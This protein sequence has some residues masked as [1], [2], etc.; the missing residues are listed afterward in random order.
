MSSSAKRNSTKRERCNNSNGNGNGNE[1]NPNFPQ[2]L[3]KRS[4][5]CTV[6]DLVKEQKVLAEIKEFIKKQVKQEV[7]KAKTENSLDIFGNLSMSSR[8]KNTTNKP[9]KMNTGGFRKTNKTKNQKN[10]KY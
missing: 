9:T 4:R 1:K 5:H 3:K 8:H 2:R 10:K 7:E 6:E